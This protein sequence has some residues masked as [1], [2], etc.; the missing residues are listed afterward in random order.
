MNE[1]RCPNCNSTNGD[2]YWRV[3]RDGG[4][5]TRTDCFNCDKVSETEEA[6]VVIED[7]L[8]H[9]LHK[10]VLVTFPDEDHTCILL[11]D[12]G[13]EAYEA[14]LRPEDRFWPKHVQAVYSTSDCGLPHIIVNQELGEVE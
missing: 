11:Q 4:K 14:G 8:A 12:K 3:D 1:I 7:A 2:S 10:F 5:Y 13:D 6:D 9:L